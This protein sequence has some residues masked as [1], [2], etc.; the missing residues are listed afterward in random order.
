M[1]LNDKQK[2]FCEEY[3]IDLNATQAIP[4]SNYYVYAILED[5]KIC[6]VGKGTK[7]RVL[8][9]FKKGDSLISN[10]IA[11]NPHRY[12]WVIINEFKSETAAF[13]SEKELIYLLKDKGFKLYNTIHYKKDKERFNQIN[14]AVSILNNLSAYWFKKNDVVSISELASRTLE[15]L[16]KITLNIPNERMPN[17]F[18]ID[19]QNLSFDVIDDQYFQK[20]VLKELK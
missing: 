14:L 2:R 6:Y 15:I 9:H 10:M 18:N 8:Q 5:D 20:I 3:L 4:V 12:R 13:E 1:A 19:I 11:I 16:K 17:Y 7:K